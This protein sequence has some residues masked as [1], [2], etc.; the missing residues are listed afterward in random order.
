V[1]VPV[2]RYEHDKNLNPSSNF[3]SLN[4]VVLPAWVG[5]LIAS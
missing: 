2:G 1:I 4:L 3:V 5:T